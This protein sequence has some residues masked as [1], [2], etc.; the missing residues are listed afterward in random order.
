MSKRAQALA[1]RLEQGVGELIAFV[2]RL[3][4]AEWQAVRPGDGRTVG[5]IVHH[6]AS[7]YPVEID[8]ARTLASGQ[9]ITDVTW[10]MVN[11]MNAQHAGE[12]AS[13]SKADALDLLRR[14]SASAADAVRALSDE[15]LDRA[16]P[17]SLNWDAPLTT[18]YFIEEH[19]V[20]HSFRHLA[21]I[22]AVI[23]A[24]ASA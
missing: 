6:V 24:S 17:I 1:D 2:E 12:H 3:S 7:A 13:T 16:A 19:P 23:E 21:N 4:E 5:V 10:E 14:N 18:Q 22:R 8:L 20:S 9:A 15:E 11:Q